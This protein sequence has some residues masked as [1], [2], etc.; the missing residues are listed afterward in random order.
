[1]SIKTRKAKMP[2]SQF[3][4]LRSYLARMGMGQNDINN[5]IG[6]AASGRSRAQI[7][8]ELRLYLKQTAH[9]PGAKGL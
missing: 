4:Q 2:V 3:G 9:K 7:A 8:W 1:M 5:A 6:N